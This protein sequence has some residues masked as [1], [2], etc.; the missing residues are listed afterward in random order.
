MEEPAQCNKVLGVQ[1]RFYRIA[2]Q[3]NF[4]NLIDFHKPVTNALCSVLN[5]KLETFIYEQK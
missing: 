1:Q 5:Q 3:H 4:D 2:R